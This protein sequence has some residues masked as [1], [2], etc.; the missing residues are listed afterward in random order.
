VSVGNGLQRRCEGIAAAGAGGAA[1][2]IGFEADV[3]DA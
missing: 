3:K 2:Q 1:G